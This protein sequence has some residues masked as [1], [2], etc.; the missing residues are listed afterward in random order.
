MAPLMWFERA[1]VAFMSVLCIVFDAR[2]EPKDRLNNAS[3]PAQDL[4][5]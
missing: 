1:L 3:P 4:W 5:G 2:H